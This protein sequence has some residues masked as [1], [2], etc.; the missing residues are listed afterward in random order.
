MKQRI[1]ITG[2][3]ACGKSLVTEI[4]KQ[5]GL[6]V[7][8]ADMV[9]R[10]VVKPGSIGLK[11]VIAFFGQAFLLPDG[12]LNRKKLGELV[13]H[14]PLY[15]QKLNEITKPLI[16][17][18]I[19]QQ[20]EA[21]SDAPLIFVDAALLLEDADY[22]QLVD[23]IWLVTATEVQQVERLQHRNGYTEAHAR[24][25]IAAQMPTDE[26]M[27]LAD[28][29]IDNSGSMEHTKQQMMALLQKYTPMRE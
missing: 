13:F 23:G 19:K 6:P 8:D 28:E 5:Q 2:G 14:E 21:E 16:L 10:T 26:K 11:Q 7:I 29:I 17:A 25:R 4:I 9:A 22:R 18:E 27:K 1:G 12:S 15:L 3:I 24:A 20:L